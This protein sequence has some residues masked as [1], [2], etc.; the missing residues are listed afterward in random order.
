MKDHLLINQP[1][2][3]SDLTFD[4]LYLEISED[5]QERAKRLQARRWHHLRRLAKAGRYNYS[6]RGT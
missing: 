1:V 3:L 5:W 4:D 6:A 2:K